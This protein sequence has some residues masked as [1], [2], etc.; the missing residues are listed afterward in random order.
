MTKKDT[1]KKDPTNRDA[2]KKQ[3]DLVI[4]DNIVFGYFLN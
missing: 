1:R 2:T 4:K 3:G